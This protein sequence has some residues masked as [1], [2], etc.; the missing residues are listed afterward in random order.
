MEFRCT[1]STAQEENRQFPPSKGRLWVQLSLPWLW[2]WSWS[3]S[4]DQGR[5][6]QGPHPILTLGSKPKGELHSLPSCFFILP[7]LTHLDHLNHCDFK[8]RVEKVPLLEH[9]NRRASDSLTVPCPPPSYAS[10]QA[11]A[12]TVHKV[13]FTPRPET[14]QA[15]GIFRSSLETNTSH[16]AFQVLLAVVTENPVFRI[17]IASGWPLLTSLLSPTDFSIF[18][19]VRI[20]LS[21]RLPS[22]K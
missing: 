13:C 14:N 10:K 17:G 11:F 16:S 7:L 15:A 5:K 6:W 2:L 9:K 3:L 4:G 12:S 19:F 18:V 21:D 20:K 22:Q 8:S 1:Y